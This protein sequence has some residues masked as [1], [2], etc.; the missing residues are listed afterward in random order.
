MFRCCLWYDCFVKGDIM[1]ILNTEEINEI[2]DV[3]TSGGIVALPT[4]T[5]YGF[6]CLAT[7]N[8][9]IS[10]LCKL[11]ER[12]DG[13]QFIL[14]VSS[15]YD[16]SKLVSLS[17]ATQEF[18]LEHTPN[19]LTMIVNKSSSVKLADIFELPTLAI[20]IPNNAFLEAILDKVGYMVSTSCNLQG[21]PFLNDYQSIMS[22]FP[23]IDA[24]VRAEPNIASPSTIV[25]L[26][27][28]E[29]KVVRQGGYIIK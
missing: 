11:K 10:R 22:A 7:D 17:G 13:K 15:K 28:E 29:I 12:E 8:N 19:N 5:I 27:S 4:D 18:V 23:S 9:A 25:D 24:I 1:K 21:E 14:L 16:L 20:R 26:T 2:V 6:S 3:I